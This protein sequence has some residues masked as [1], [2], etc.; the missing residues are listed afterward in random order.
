MDIGIISKRYAKAL[1]E[2]AKAVDA[3]DRIYA[4]VRVLWSSLR[5]H[6]ELRAAMDNP[7]LSV[8]QKYALLRTATAGR[9]QVSQEM[10]RLLALVLR[11][12][13][14]SILLYICLSYINLYRKLR[15]IGRA[16]LI[17]A[18]PLTPEMEERMKRGASA[19]LHATIEF[20][21]EVR[22]EIQGGFIFDINDYR[23]D[24]SVATQLKR[25]KAQF[26]E[27]NRRIV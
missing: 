3:V 27:K 24:A 10:D 18:V 8:D 5:E 23:L 14:E 4:E 16:R 2:Y 6:P 7:M 19:H 25:V 15:R 11:N 9:G 13:R 1:L 21:A 22:P 20:D 17:T 26:I 12:G